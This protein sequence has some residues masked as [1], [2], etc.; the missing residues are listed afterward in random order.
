RLYIEHGMP[1]GAALEPDIEDVHLFAKLHDGSTSSTGRIRRQKRERIVLVPSVR[2]FLREQRDDALVDGFVVEG[3]M[4]LLAKEHRD[5][6][7]PDE[8]PGETPVGP[9]GDHVGDALF[10]PGR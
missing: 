9:C 10:S 6:H 5:R 4:A 2:S 7:T 8:L 1:A 3:L